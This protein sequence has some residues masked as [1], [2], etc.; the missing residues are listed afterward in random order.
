[1]GG[2]DFAFAWRFEYALANL[3]VFGFTKRYDAIKIN[4]IPIKR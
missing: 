1:M 3:G 2:D 4:C